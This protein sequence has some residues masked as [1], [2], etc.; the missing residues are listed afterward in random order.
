MKSLP[1][2][3]KCLI[4]VLALF[5]SAACATLLKHHGGIYFGEHYVEIYPSADLSSADCNALNEIVGK[6][7]KRIYKIQSFKDGEP[8][9]AN[10]RLCEDCMR[11]GLVAD[12]M[13]QAKMLHFTGCALQAGLNFGGSST[14]CVKC[15]GDGKGR[16]AGSST[17][18]TPTPVE[19]RG[20]SS[21]RPTPTP[22]TAMSSSTHL[23]AHGK[24]S[25]TKLIKQ[26]EK[27]VNELKPILERYN[28][29]K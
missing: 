17:H 28:K 16:A 11:E 2:T 3:V 26:S 20:G 14:R 1:G 8:G 12:V 13:R 25:S 24:P 19:A 15:L 5:A 9:K 29:K 27:L 21:T 6:Y 18:P 10:G 4:V 23:S 7:D 22:Y